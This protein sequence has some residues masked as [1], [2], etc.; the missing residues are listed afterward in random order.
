MIMRAV[1]PSLQHVSRGLILP[2]P[3]YLSGNNFFSCHP[4]AVSLLSALCQRADI[5]QLRRN[6][7][8][9]T[10]PP[11]RVVRNLGAAYAN[12]WTIGVYTVPAARSRV[13]LQINTPH[14]IERGASRKPLRVARPPSEQQGHRNKV[15]NGLPS[16]S[17]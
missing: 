3:L 6:G 5:F 7:I 11:S 8:Y 2:Y 16:L 15:L 12:T 9:L 13:T 17:I 4:P 1:A 14:T 10:F